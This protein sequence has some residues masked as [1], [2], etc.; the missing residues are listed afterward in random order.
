MRKEE[1]DMRIFGSTV[2]FA[3][4]DN[5]K[6]NIFSPSKTKKF[7]LGTYMVKI[8]LNKKPLIKKER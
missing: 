8:L 2:D 4:N 5:V 6:H 1:E 3:N 7:N